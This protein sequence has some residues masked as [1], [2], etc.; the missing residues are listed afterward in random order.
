MLFLDSL[1]WVGVSFEVSNNDILSNDNRLSDVDC[2][3]LN[4]C[5]W[6]I[7]DCE[8]LFVDCWWLLPFE[9]RICNSSF[10]RSLTLLNIAKNDRNKVGIIK[11][12]N[13]FSKYW[14]EV[15][16]NHAVLGKSQFNFNL[17]NRN[18]CNRTE[19]LLVLCSFF[20]SNPAEPEV[21][22]SQRTYLVALCV[23]CDFM[24]GTLHNWPLMPSQRVAKPCF[25]I[26]SFG[27]DR[28]FLV[29]WGHGLV[30]IPPFSK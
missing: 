16:N 20:L 21:Q 26:F 11:L 19:N 10:W 9:N 12:I 27:H 22:C 15:G 4:D 23:H 28:F 25:P 30:S 14:P 17:Y 29:K 6:L 2:G 18:E 3:F 8:L 5:E 1:G 13:W 7:V 24:R